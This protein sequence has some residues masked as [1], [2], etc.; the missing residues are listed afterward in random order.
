ME[1]SGVLPELKQIIGAMI[2]GA[3]RI[4]TAN[5]IKKCLVEVAEE[6]GGE[7]EVFAKVSKRD[8]DG[9]VA[10]LVQDL[11]RMKCGFTI[12]EVAGGFKCQS[13]SVCGKWLS[14]LLAAGKPNRLSRPALETLAV[15]AYR[16]PVAKSTIE[17]V[18]GVGVDHVIKTLIEMQ[19]VRIAGRS[20]LPGRPFLY[21]TT[22][23]FLEHFGLKDLKELKEVGP[24]LLAE[25]EAMDRNA[26]KE[27]K[28]EAEEAAEQEAVVVV[29]AEDDG[30]ES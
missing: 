25:K 10:E 19:L 7:V 9:A 12:D 23:S 16:Q 15:I 6:N 3:N 14:H 30:D 24:A 22:Q 17:G 26:R 13:D 18:R 1:K 5:E 4:L 29:E 11:E 2:F 28:Q 27:E 8:I 21:G 20:E